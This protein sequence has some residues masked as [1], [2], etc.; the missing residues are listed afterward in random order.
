MGARLLPRNLPELFSYS[1]ALERE[2]TRRYAELEK[3]LRKCG[4]DNLADEFEKIGREEQ[5][6]YEMINLGTAG[7]DL[8]ELAGWELA[9]HFSGEAFQTR[10]APRS[11]REAIAMALAFERRIQAF[12]NDVAESARDDAV[13]AFAAEMCNDEQRHVARL[14][15]LLERESD[16]T[17]IEMGASGAGDALVP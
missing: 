9:W 16:A 10:C 1:L 4:I 12:Y 11:T 8:P 6:Q 17:T 13:R 5:E 2:A 7:R 14:E 3:F 15:L